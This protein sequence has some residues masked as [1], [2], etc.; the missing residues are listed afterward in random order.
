MSCIASDINKRWGREKQAQINTT[1]PQDR[2]QSES[3]REWPCVKGR[4]KAWR[5]ATCHLCA[6]QWHCAPN[7]NGEAMVN[8]ASLHGRGAAIGVVSKG[9]ASCPV[10]GD[11]GWHSLVCG[12]TPVASHCWRP[13]KKKKPTKVAGQEK[14][15]RSGHWPGNGVA[16]T[17]LSVNPLGK[18]F[19]HPVAKLEQLVLESTEGGL[20]VFV[21]RL[22]RVGADFFFFFENKKQPR[23]I[24]DVLCRLLKARVAPGGAARHISAKSIPDAIFSPT[25]SA[26]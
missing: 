21:C 11:D 9:R 26:R 10:V 23:V 20:S 16:D 8:E 14:V 15:Q 25:I 22:L 18:R 17:C 7:C 13:D 24:D 6:S 5:N 1:T 3:N 2:R 4:D 19:H 12:W